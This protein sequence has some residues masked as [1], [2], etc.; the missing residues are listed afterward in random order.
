M[1]KSEKG[2]ATVELAIA[3]TLIT[4]ILFSIIDFG[5]IFHAYLALENA[6]REAARQASLGA[7]DTEVI[8]TAYST[9]PSL[10]DDLLMVNITP[11][12]L[13]RKSGI[14]VTVTLSYPISPSI[15]GLKE[16]LPDSLMIKSKTVM[17]V[18]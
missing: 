7:A 4:L 1:I 14:Y 6:G 11:S 13:N 18:E 12:E 5:R 16:I 9:A 2:Q 3:L 10:D 8:R 17:R 15:P